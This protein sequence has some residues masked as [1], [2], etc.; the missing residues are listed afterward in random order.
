MVLVVRP[1]ACGL[2]MVL[3]CPVELVLPVHGLCPLRP[4]SRLCGRARADSGWFSLARRSALCCGLSVS[5]ARK[6]HVHLCASV[7]PVRCCF[8]VS[9]ARRCSAVGGPMTTPPS[10]VPGPQGPACGGWAWGATRPRSCRRVSG[11]GFASS[12]GLPAQLRP[13]VGGCVPSLVPWRPLSCP[14]ASRQLPVRPTPSGGT[15]RR[16]ICP[17]PHPRLR[18]GGGR[19]SCGP[20]AP[21]AGVRPRP[22]VP[23]GRSCLREL[24]WMR[25]MHR[26]GAPPPR[27][28][29]LGRPGIVSWPDATTS[30]PPRRLPS[31]GG[32]AGGGDPASLEDVLPG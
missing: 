21:L 32:M 13:T 29:S 8:S 22:S 5:R 31:P 6:S 10:C 23:T 20:R 27:A 15:L 4:S 17:L 12:G 26:V 9:R 16:P 28:P 2:W 18:R 19:T 14:V 25:W 1:C 11:L 7:P 3:L 24:S 30:G